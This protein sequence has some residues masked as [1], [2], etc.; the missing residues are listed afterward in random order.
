MINYIFLILIV[1]IIFYIFN[2]FI[3]INENFNNQNKIVVTLT[4]LPERI[5]SNH[6][7]KVINSLLN[8]KYK[9]EY[10]LLNIPYMYKNKKYIIPIWIKQ[11]KNIRINRCK[12]YGPATKFLGLL[13]IVPKNYLLFIC[14]D[15]IVYSNN[16]LGNMRKMFISYNNNY[17]VLA[18]KVARKYSLNEPLGFSGIMCKKFLI[19][20]IS[21][22]QRPKSC[23]YIDDTFLAWTFNKLGVNVVK[24]YLKFDIS[25]M[26]KDHPEWYELCK[27]TDRKNDTYKCVHELD[28]IYN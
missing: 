26:T 22:F 20:K 15:D 9:P 19:D 23:F 14:D 2:N 7:R 5:I 6:F 28:Y 13:N 4:T 25:E 12:D 24:T 27:D 8:Q 16:I 17:I 11:N 21:K 3:I 10:I 18:N 1:L